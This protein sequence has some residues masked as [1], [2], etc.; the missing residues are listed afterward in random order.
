MLQVPDMN[1]INVILASASPRRKELLSVIFDKFQIVVS[2]V[3]ENVPDGIKNE[4]QPEYLARLKALDVAK[5]N[6]DSLVIGADTSVLAD[7]I[8]LGKPKSKDE[9][10]DM[11][12]LLSGR[13]HKVITGCCICL[14]GKSHSFSVTT[15]VNF[16]ELSEGE[17]NNYI[18]T[19]EPY[20]K[21]G[22]YGIQSKGGLFVK[23][24]RGDYF[25]VVGLPVAELKREIDNFIKRR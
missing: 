5:S 6:P 3:E 7:G 9:A 17:I 22:G 1:I 21:A 8:I 12:K 25:N 11:L 4:N 15:Y 14:N 23:G 2:D 13:S 18:D 20:D 19:L 10:Y 16:Y 24:I